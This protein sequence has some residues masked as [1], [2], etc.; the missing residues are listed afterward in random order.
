MTLLNNTFDMRDH[1]FF[2]SNL[3]DL[4]FFFYIF[5]ELENLQALIFYIKLMISCMPLE[6]SFYFLFFLFKG[7]LIIL[8]QI[9]VML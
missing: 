7:Y 3:L 5:L 4:L 9:L 6:M 2:P 8:R 1:L